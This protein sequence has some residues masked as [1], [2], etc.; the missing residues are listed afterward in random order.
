MVSQ[1][2]SSARAAGGCAAGAHAAGA[3]DRLRFILSDDGRVSAVQ[4]DG[5]SIVST[6]TDPFT[7]FAP[8]IFDHFEPLIAMW[9]ERTD[10]T[11]RVYWSNV[12]NTFE[13]MLRR[14]ESV[15]GMTPRLREAQR[16]LDEPLWPDGRINPLA[17]AVHYE[18]DIRLR[19]ICCLQY[20]LP[21]R[22]FCKACPIDEAQALHHGTNAAC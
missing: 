22:R 14:I 13:A 4:L 17:G 1:H 11:R 18:N 2:V 15:T 5:S 12:G 19:R 9:S 8:L 7:R 6:G 3:L 21:D 10:V 16:L 20:L